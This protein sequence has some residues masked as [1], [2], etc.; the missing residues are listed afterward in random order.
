MAD[1]DGKHTCDRGHPVTQMTR[2]ANINHE[3]PAEE[4]SWINFIQTVLGE[5][6][7]APQEGRYKCPRCGRELRVLEDGGEFQFETPE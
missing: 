7:G 4:K 6:N 5:D 1:P 3:A 2:V